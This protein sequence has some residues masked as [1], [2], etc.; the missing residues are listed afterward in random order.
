MVQT[1]FWK[2]LSCDLYTLKRACP[3]CGAPTRNPLPPRFSPKDPYARYRGATAGE[4]PSPG[5]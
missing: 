2:C 3:K 5:N 4:A 1:K